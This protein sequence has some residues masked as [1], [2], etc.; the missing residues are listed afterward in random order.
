MTLD[1]KKLLLFSAFMAS[2][3]CSLLLSAKITVFMGLT[4]T[5]GA[6]SYAVLFAVTDIVSEVW[7]RKEANKLV[8]IGWMVY[9]L[10]IVYSQIAQLMPPAVFWAENQAA[11]ETVFGIVPRI[12]LGSLASYTVSQY[13]DIWIFHVLKNITGEKYL[14]LRNNLSTASSQFIDTLIF[15]SI[16]FIGI[17]PNSALIGLIIGQY[18]IKLMIALLDTP[19]VYALVKWTRND[20]R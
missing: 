12:I 1:T 13:Y 20:E 6:I 15:V 3:T 4:F 2:L 7:G 18:V 16:A 14:W 9:G 19:I 17:V 11:Y 10:V 5:V 8:Y